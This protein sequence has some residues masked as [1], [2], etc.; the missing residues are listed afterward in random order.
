MV[1]DVN[2]KKRTEIVCNN[3]IR[4]VSIWNE[5]VKHS[6]NNNGGYGPSLTCN[7]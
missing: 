1:V 3:K 2:G 7:K 4:M 6:K 5:N